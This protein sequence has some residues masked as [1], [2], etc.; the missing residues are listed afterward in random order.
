MHVDA[1]RLA[2]LFRP[3]GDSLVFTFLKCCMVIYS[4]RTNMGCMWPN[5][6]AGKT[7]ENVKV[8]K[9]DFLS[10]GAKFFCGIAESCR[11]RLSFSWKARQCSSVPSC[12]QHPFPGH[13]VTR[14]ALMQVSCKLVRKISF[15]MCPSSETSVQVNSQSNLRKI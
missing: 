15:S 14:K 3:H 11:R 4:I 7:L 9:R 12:M 13:R 1:E 10:C 2:K 5:V 6:H 8:R